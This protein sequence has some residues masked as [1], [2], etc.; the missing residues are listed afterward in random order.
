MM[1]ANSRKAWIALLLAGV[2]GLA[3]GAVGGYIGYF[4]QLKVPLIALASDSHTQPFEHTYNEMARFRAL[5]M[6]AANCNGSADM[7]K[8]IE[9]E[10]R[11][12][13]LLESSAT[14][15]KLTPQLNVARAIVAYRSAT[16]AEARS[17]KQAF[18]S[19]VEQEKA[20]LQAAGWK[21]TSHDHLA[22]V[23]RELDGCSEPNTA[24]QEKNR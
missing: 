15:A 10:N 14:A 4:L 11:L 5:E 6:S 18:N 8:V 2:V 20:F 13:G 7:S 12:I 16:L 22:R 24:A 1:T 3:I 19:A 9:N 21:D 17:D 23:V